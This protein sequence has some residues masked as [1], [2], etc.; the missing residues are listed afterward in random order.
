MKLVAVGQHQ[1]GDGPVTKATPGQ[2][3]TV[4]VG[5]VMVKQ[6]VADD[7]REAE[8]RIKLVIR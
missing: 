4:D 3:A 1:Q 8:V 7:G 5:K 6:C 2:T